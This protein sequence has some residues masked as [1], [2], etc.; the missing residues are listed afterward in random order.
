[1]RATKDRGAK[2]AKSAAAK[3]HSRVRTAVAMRDQFLVLSVLSDDRRLP[4]VGEMTTGQ[5]R[6]ALD[7]HNKG[8]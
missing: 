7:A 3:E 2:S 5:A 6:G 1:M 8:W 4:K